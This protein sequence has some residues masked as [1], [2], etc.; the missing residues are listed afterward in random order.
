M[1]DQARPLKQFPDPSVHTP[2]GFDTGDP[3]AAGNAAN[4]KTIVDAHALKQSQIDADT[5]RQ[6]SD[7]FQAL[8]SERQQLFAVSLRALNDAVTVSSRISA[9]GAT[10][11]AKNL[12]KD[13][14]DITSEAVGAQVVAD[15]SPAITSAVE[16]AVAQSVGDQSVAHGALSAA[17]AE[18]VVSALSE[19]SG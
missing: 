16:A 6:G 4:F 19:K 15:I 8:Q 11:D 14:T 17:I 7:L 18:A 5:I 10:M 12:D 1:E 9:N 2:V 13:T 3:Y